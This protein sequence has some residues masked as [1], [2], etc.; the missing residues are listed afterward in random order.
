MSSPQSVLKQYWHFDQF[1]PLQEEII[2][3][4][5]AGKDCVAL[6]PT[7]GGKSLCFQI[8][9]IVLHG[10]TI[11]VS[12]LVSLMQDQVTQLKARGIETAY[13]HGGLS[14][15]EVAQLLEDAEKG[16]F[17]LLY[18]APERL[19]SKAFKDALPYLNLSLIAVDEAHC[20]SQWGHDFR[21]DF[22]Q[23]KTLRE[24]WK[25]VPILALTASATQ[26]V[27]LDIQEQLDIK[28]AAIFRKSFQR[29]NIFYSIH[30]SEN[31]QQYIVRYFSENPH[32]GIIYCRSRKKTEELALLLRQN[33]ISAIAYH[34]GMSKE[35]RSEAQELWT[36][37]KIAVIV[38]TNAFGMG[39][40]KADV[41]TVI[42]YDTPEH[43]E[44]Y[45][46][47]TGR[48]GRDGKAAKAICLYHSS[49]I[50]RLRNSTEIYFPP[51]SFLRKVYQC[52][53]DFLQ[54]ASGT[55]PNKYFDF[56]LAKFI[57][58]FKLEALPTTHA[59]RLL[60][61]EGLWT[62]SE[63]LFRPAT[64]RFV[65][66]RQILDDIHQRYPILGLVSTG[67]LR[68]Y[69]G[70]FHYPTSIHLLSLA[71]YLKMQKED[72]EQSLQQLQQMNIIHYQKA[73]D[74]AL[75]YFH[76]YRVPSQELILNRK[77]IKRLRNNHQR[78][79]DI[80]IDFLNNK[81]ICH[82]HIL[83]HYFDENATDYCSHCAIC[84]AHDTAE[85]K[86]E[87][88]MD[89]IM[90]LLQRHKTLSLNELLL[91]IG[92]ENTNQSTQIIRKM[93]EEQLLYLNE[94]GD[95]MAYNT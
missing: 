72:I 28:D 86:P 16:A 59:L 22:L 27:L 8:P 91:L 26:D 56:D 14:Y 3:C 9:A 10:L 24:V 50:E 80:M 6:L 39:I 48:A 2:N 81:E 87:M 58:N 37:N 20:I 83:L 60:A 52:I 76:H 11:V 74:G 43:L 57:Q 69:S 34:A 88:L 65:V 13:L 30:Y 71:R 45:Y 62:L 23:I 29:E 38:A 47:E 82:N 89:V 31:K 66:E 17:K 40:D 85:F 33:N 93:I 44:A 61:Q 36:K 92:N 42:H 4:I 15:K 64:V 19:Q 7:G 1:R 70:I 75:L 51:E 53:C 55:E 79:T 73:K 32:C 25:T 84:L 77:R 90:N 46:Q 12:P 95:I 35:G 63:S 54:I 78:R 94:E 18:L 21:P 41:R 49:D 67:L 5:L 68:M